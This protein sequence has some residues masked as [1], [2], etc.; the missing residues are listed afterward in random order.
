MKRLKR[1][2]KRTKGGW[3]TDLYREERCTIRNGVA[4]HFSYVDEVV[5][6]WDECVQQVALPWTREPDYPGY[7]PSTRTPTEQIVDNRLAHPQT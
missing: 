2:T 4:D 6:V 5:L 3:P 1:R 7:T